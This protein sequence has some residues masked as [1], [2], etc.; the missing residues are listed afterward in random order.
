MKASL[1]DTDEDDQ[2]STMKMDDV[3]TITNIEGEL[4]KLLTID[5]DNYEISQETEVK[6]E[7]TSKRDESQEL[8]DWLDS[9][10]D[11]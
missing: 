2:P 10:L 9:V 1:T 3:S 7:I 6:T 5:H 8:E 11:G 4:D